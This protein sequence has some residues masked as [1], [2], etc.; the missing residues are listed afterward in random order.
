MD[1]TIP[2]S[3]P[4]VILYA[5]KC[6]KN[7]FG[8]GRPNVP[9]DLKGFSEETLFLTVGTVVLTLM[10]DQQAGQVAR[11]SFSCRWNPLGK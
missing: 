2:L 10:T 1:G 11:D 6:T 9:S 7:Q 3:L 5:Q 8:P 4:R